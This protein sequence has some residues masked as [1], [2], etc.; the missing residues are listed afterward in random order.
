MIITSL[1]ND[2]CKIFPLVKEYDESN[3]DLNNMRLITNEVNSKDI[4]LYDSDRLNKSNHLQTFFLNTE[5]NKEL[6]KNFAQVTEKQI[7]IYDENQMPKVIIKGLNIRDCAA[8]HDSYLYTISDAIVSPYTVKDY[9]NGEIKIDQSNEQESYSPSGFFVYDMDALFEGKITKYK[10]A[11]SVGGFANNLDDSKFGDRISFIQSFDNIVMIPFP[12]LNLLSCVGMGHKS[13]YLIW[14]EKNGFFSALDRR[15]NLLTWA[16]LTGQMLYSQS[17][18]EDAGREYVKKYEV[19]RADEQDIVH[20]QNFYNFEEYSLSL[21]KS[22]QPV[23]DKLFE[24]QPKLKLNK[25]DLTL[26]K[27]KNLARNENGNKK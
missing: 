21:L 23:D 12:H 14:R 11:S 6:N 10:L 3:K 9:S 17:Q 7:N 15:N 24:K 18:T 1:K 5:K 20:T 13:E 2:S 4:T 27:D 8:V 16:I 19:Y 22:K 25:V 26:K